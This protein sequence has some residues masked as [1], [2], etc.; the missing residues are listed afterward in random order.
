VAR[1]W[2]AIAAVLLVA[3]VAGTVL[4]VR[5]FPENPRLVEVRFPGSYEATGTI[6]VTHAGPYAIWADG[7][8]SVDADRCAVH[9]P[10]R[11][12]V[13][14]TAPKRRANWTNHAEDDAVYTWIASFDAPTAGTY[15][16]RCRPDPNAP[17]AAYLVSERPK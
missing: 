2:Y 14:V 6:A 3:G 5:R 15:T 1:V 7:G 9:T 11:E 12:N 10:S 13:I 4:M 16:I 17:G 8:P